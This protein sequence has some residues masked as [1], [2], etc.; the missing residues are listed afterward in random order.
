MSFRVLLDEIRTNL[1]QVTTRLQIPEVSFTLEPAKSEFGDVT[2]NIAFLTSKHLKKRPYDIAKLISDEYQKNLGTLV[3]K[4]EPHQSGYLNF[5]ANNAQLNRLVI[6]AAKDAIYGMVDI[7]KK[8]RVIVEHTSVNPNKALHIGHVR[9]VVVGDTIA[10]ILSKANHDVVVLNYVDDSGLQVADIIV[11]FKHLGFSET[12]PDGQKFDNYCG[13]EV[14]VKTTEQ[15]AQNKSLEEIRNNILKELEDGRSDIAKFGKS[16][17][18]RVLAE[19]LK[20]CWRLGAYYDCLNFE[21]EIVRSHLWPDIFEKLKKMN[22]IKYE[23]EGKNAGCWV[24]L[25]QDED[26]VLVRSNGTATYIAKDIPYAAWKLGLVDDPFYYKKYSVQKNNKVLWQTTLE[27]NRDPKQHFRSNVVVTVIDSRQ[28][29]LQNIITELISKFDSSQK[30]YLHLGYESVTLSADTANVLGIDTKGKNTQMSGRK[31][32]YINAD[33]VLDMLEQK[34]ID[35]TKKRNPDLSNESLHE[36]ASKVAVATL[37]YEMIK[38]DLDKI[39]T[40]DYSKSLSLDGDTAPYI[41]YAYARAVRI[42]EKA[43]AKPDF[44]ASYEL[45]DSEYETNLVKL[46]GRFDLN[47][48]DAANNLSPKVI[49]KYCHNLAVT[50]NVFYE[51]VKVLDS[52]NADT[53]NA[54]LC[55]VHSFKSCLEN[56]LNLLGIE[57]P[58]RM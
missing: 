26:K 1:L 8:S 38:Q 23:S 29:R 16:V 10:R 9:N 47:V 53:V 4:V 22:L 33:S 11:G 41:Q 21:S 3:S 55:L 52:E 24:I 30:S 54:R 2:C 12:P 14:Y 25:S 32:L 6:N 42:L 37:R 40:F 46:I 45:L 13:D 50:F 35:E 39:I 20:T 56:A 44:E 7:G 5:Y 57:T 48:E 49:A 15:Y 34:T 43:Q 19:Q 17:T 27:E 18:N 31:G 28:A 51:H 58:S 36:I